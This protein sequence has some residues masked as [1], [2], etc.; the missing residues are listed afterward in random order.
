MFAPVILPVQV[1]VLVIVGFI[2]CAT[3]L[4]PRRGYS[5]G[6]VL[7]YCCL[8]SVALFVPSCVAIGFVVDLFRYGEFSYRRAS[9]ITDP[10]IRI[11]KS[12][13]DIMVF[14]FASGHDLRFS[15]AEADLLTW[16][17]EVSAERADEKKRYTFG[18]SYRRFS[19]HN[20]M[21]SEAMDMYASPTSPRGSGFHVW[22]SRESGIA[23]LDALYW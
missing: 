5:S 3:A 20:W 17:G 7:A 10:Y 6:K 9:E 14:K 16:L 15:V 21:I 4:L 11:P 22:Y 13:T 18:A 12:A 23:C 1:T 2:I 19:Q 8:G